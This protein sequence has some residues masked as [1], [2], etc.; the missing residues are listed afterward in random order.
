MEI[1]TSC[2]QSSDGQACL[3]EIRLEA[4]KVPKPRAILTEQ[5]AVHIFELKQYTMSSHGKRPLSA[6]GI[7]RVFG[8]NEKTVRDIWKGRTWSRETW[9]LDCSR[10]ILIKQPGKPKGCKDT[11]QRQRRISDRQ[12]PGH[13]E[14]PVDR[15]AGYNR[16]LSGQV[17]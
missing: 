10:Q 4:S 13:E 9:H 7:A 11:K 16:S 3:I 15:L 14:Q 2:N 5:Q 8:V 12:M 1:Q 17:V 6:A